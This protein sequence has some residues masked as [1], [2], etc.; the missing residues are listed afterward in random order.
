VGG[1]RRGKIRHA[2]LSIDKTTGSGIGE[3][4]SHIEQP[5]SQLLFTLTKK[6]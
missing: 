1:N 5:P 6:N 4:E 2:T 3:E